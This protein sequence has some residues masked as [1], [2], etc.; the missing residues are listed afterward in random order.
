MTNKVR[1]S[2][3]GHPAHIADFLIDKHGAELD[4]QTRR[5][6]KG[7]ISSDSGECEAA[8]KHLCKKFGYATRWVSYENEVYEET[9]W[10]MELFKPL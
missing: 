4:S 9:I 5:S 6:L 2:V 10:E 7:M 8:V 1:Q 3:I